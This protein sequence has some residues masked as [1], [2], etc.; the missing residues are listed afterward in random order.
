MFCEEYELQISFLAWLFIS[1]QIEE[2]WN[3]K[4]N[5]LTEDIL[6]LEGLRRI[7][8]WTYYWQK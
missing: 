1:R 3:N 5:S 4:E 7:L 2:S 6:S 8:K